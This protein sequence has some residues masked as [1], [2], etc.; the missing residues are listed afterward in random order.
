VKKE[1]RERYQ[2]GRKIGRERKGY[3]E[4]L[5]PTYTGVRDY[6]TEGCLL[7]GVRSILYKENSII[8]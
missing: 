2:N 5:C 8:Y 1:E 3:T 6:R 7:L 4:R